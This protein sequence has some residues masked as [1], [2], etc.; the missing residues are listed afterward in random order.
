MSLPNFLF[1][2]V[3]DSQK[4]TKKML[5]EIEIGS[6]AGSHTKHI[7]VQEKEKVSIREASR[8]MCCLGGGVPFKR[9]FAETGHFISGKI[10][11]RFLYLI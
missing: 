1:E 3:I 9:D 4:V 11:A 2:S 5:W 7:L 8:G 6:M 10:V